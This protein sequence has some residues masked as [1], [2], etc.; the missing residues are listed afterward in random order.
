MSKRKDEATF[1]TDLI[2]EIK[3]RLPGSYVFHLDSSERQGVPDLLVIYQDRWA[4]LEGKKHSKASYQKNQHYYVDLFNK[5]SFA[6]SIYPEN[7]EEVL[8]ELER[9]LSS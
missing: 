8:D 2:K 9:S 4:M 1:K 7:R 3:Q 6:R 5:M